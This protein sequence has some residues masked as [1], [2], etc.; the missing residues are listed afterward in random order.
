M[1]FSV[2]TAKEIL[3]FKVG[4]GIKALNNYPDFVAFAAN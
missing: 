1:Y 4:R 3:L 2:S